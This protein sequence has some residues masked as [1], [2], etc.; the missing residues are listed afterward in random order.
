MTAHSILGN[1][2]RA[3][4]SF[5]TSGKIDIASRVVRA[6][7]MEPGDV[8]DIMAAGRA[9]AQCFPSKHG[10]RHFRAYSRRLC[11][12]ILRESGASSLAALPAGDLTEVAG[13][14]AIPVITRNNL[15][16]D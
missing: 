10:S 1:T 9:E 14:P 4:I 12:V 15:H 13:R 11:S 6:L 5:W 8:I 2:R 7:R 3:D 16:H